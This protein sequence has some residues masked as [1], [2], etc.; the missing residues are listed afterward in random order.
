MLWLKLTVFAAGLKHPRGAWSASF[1]LGV[2]VG[3]KKN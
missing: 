3:T 2:G 1:F